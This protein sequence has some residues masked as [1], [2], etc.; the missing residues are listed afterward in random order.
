[1]NG[2]RP[3]E[4]QIGE[5]RGGGGSSEL[6][7]CEGKGGSGPSELDC[8]DELGLLAREGAASRMREAHV[9]A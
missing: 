2:G 5:G 7:C 9:G 3:S 8:G 4:L 6:E 1:M